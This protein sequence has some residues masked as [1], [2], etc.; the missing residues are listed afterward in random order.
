MG[1]IMFMCPSTGNA[2]STGIEVDKGKFNRTPVFI[3]HT[4]CPI[5]KIDH[6]WFARDV[7]VSELDS[8]RAGQ[9]GCGE[10]RSYAFDDLAESFAE[11]EIDEAGMPKK[12]LCCGP[13]VRDG[14]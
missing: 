12:I 6:E 3:G 8:N 10:P 5:C 9:L 14:R 2:I 4:K 11:R 1:I 13:L 7:W